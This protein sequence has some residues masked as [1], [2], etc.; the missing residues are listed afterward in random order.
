MK[1][2][3]EAPLSGAEPFPKVWSEPEGP[4]EDVPKH[5][6]LKGIIPLCYPSPLGTTSAED[7]VQNQHLPL[8][9]QI[10][11]TLSG[12]AATSSA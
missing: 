3:P 7:P 11:D 2:V 6:M 9:K 8:Q 4:S 12:S 1:S 5:T 10:T